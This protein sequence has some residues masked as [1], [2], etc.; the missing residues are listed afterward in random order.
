MQRPN[1]TLPDIIN[2]V[3]KD[4]T[5]ILNTDEE[6]VEN[7][8]EI[9][10]SDYFSETDF[11]NFQ[12]SKRISNATHFTILSLNIANVLSKLSSLKTMIHTIS[13]ESNHPSLISVT[14]THLNENR[15][16]GYSQSE[17]KNL[18]PGYKFFHKDRKNKKGGGVGIFINNKMADIFEI[19]MIKIFHI[20]SKRA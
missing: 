5:K 16:Q 2:D 19:S 7:E 3:T 20:A 8:S 15:C 17:L 1:L 6:N 14:E 11:T 9:K 18:L 10:T 12:K 13:N 4:F